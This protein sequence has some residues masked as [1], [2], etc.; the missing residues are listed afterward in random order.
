MTEARLIAAVGFQADPSVL[1]GERRP[2]R[3]WLAG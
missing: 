3:G 2:H 1:S